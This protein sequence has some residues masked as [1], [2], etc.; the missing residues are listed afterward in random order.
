MKRYMLDTNTVSHLIKEHPIVAR[1][2]VATP[3]ASLCISS[4]TEGELLF[5]LAK[6]PEASRLHLAERELLRRVDVLPWSSA[7]A[8]RN[9]VVR[10]EMARLAHNDYLEQASDSGIPGFLLY[11]AAVVGGL[12]WV[13]QPTAGG[14]PVRLGVQLGLL[15]WALHSFIE[16]HL[17]IPAMAWPAFTLLGW[18]LGSRSN[19]STAAAP[20]ATMPDA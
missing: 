8:E 11:A 10:A 16:F 9:G 14:G 6:R 19:P 2:L 15:G 18:L 17:Y 4:I 12:A 13:F 1:R 5:G 3:M 7:T 20:A